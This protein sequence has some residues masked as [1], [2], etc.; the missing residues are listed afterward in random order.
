MATQKVKV[1]GVWRTVGGEGLNKG[2]VLLG[3]DTGGSGGSGGNPILLPPDS[4]NAK[5][6][7][8]DEPMDAAWTFIS[9]HPTPISV[10]TG[11]PFTV[12]STVPKYN[13]DTDIKSGLVLRTVSGYN[14][15]AYRPFVPT[16]GTKW[17]IMARLSIGQQTNDT[18]AYITLHKE[19]PTNPYYYD[20]DCIALGIRRL[21]D[22]VEYAREFAFNGG[23][24]GEAQHQISGPMK[25]LAFTGNTDNSVWSWWSDD[26]VCWR[27][28]NQRSGIPTN[29]NI[30]YLSLWNNGNGFGGYSAWD[31]VRFLEGD[32]DLQ[33]LGQAPSF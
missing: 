25:F 18:G 5:N 30:K 7:E 24:L 33:L 11:R 21:N 32:N 3:G 15:M 26:G 20:G 31:F 17:A 29:G 14:V 10:G 12:P 13:V 28:L 19:L 1:A 23:F 6:E 8:F 9:N 27:Y 2:A 22:V 4:P 16:P